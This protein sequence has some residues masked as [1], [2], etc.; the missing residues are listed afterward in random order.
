MKPV[1]D[2]ILFD[3]DGTLTDSQPGIFESVRETLRRMDFPI[4]GPETLR[5][6]IG[7]PLWYSFVNYSGMTPEQAERA[8]DLYRQTY[9]ISGAFHNEPYPH[10]FE[11]LQKLRAA[12]AQLAVATSKPGNIAHK[13]LRHFGLLPY[14]SHVS[15][16]AEGEHDSIKDELIR[17]CLRACGVPSGR[18]VMIGDTRFDAAGARAAGTDFIGA[19]YGFGTRTELEAEGAERF[20]ASV[21]ALEPFLLEESPPKN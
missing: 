16:P 18:A 9:N 21:P 5:R 15:A 1:Y 17:S 13:V 12:G 6:F 3:L 4:P 20:A 10:I 11:L 14:F 19:L 2:L 7:P 8:V